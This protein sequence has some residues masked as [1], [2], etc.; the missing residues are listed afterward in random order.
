MK[1]AIIYTA[2]QLKRYNFIFKYEIQPTDGNIWENIPNLFLTN[3]VPQKDL[4]CKP[5]PCLKLSKNSVDGRIS[6]FVSHMGLNSFLESSQAGVP[7]ISIPLFVDQGHNARCGKQ[8]PWKRIIIMLSC[9]KE[10]WNWSG[11]GESDV[12]GGRAERGRGEGPD[13]WKVRSL[14]STVKLFF[15]FKLK[16]TSIAQMLKSQPN[17]MKQRFIEW[18]EFVATHKNLHEVYCLFSISPKGNS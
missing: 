13:W 5:M 4:L 18:T 8:I 17:S 15:S 11:T 7:M 14:M 16:V 12:Y 10:A 1:D 9:S 2:K 6:A 3:W